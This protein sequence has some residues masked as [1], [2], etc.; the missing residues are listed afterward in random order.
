MYFLLVHGKQAWDSGWVGVSVIS[1]RK[2]WKDGQLTNRYWELEL[3]ILAQ[4]LQEKVW[5][6]CMS[7]AT[8]MVF[9]VCL[10]IRRDDKRQNCQVIDSCSTY[11][12]PSIA[13]QVALLIIW[14]VLGT[15]PTPLVR[16]CRTSRR[17]R[18]HSRSGVLSYSWW[19]QYPKAFL[20]CNSYKTW[21]CSF[22]HRTWESLYHWPANTLLIIT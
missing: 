10:Y 9:N 5:Y 13:V 17:R 21:R 19:R 2:Y 15:G 14:K 20:W 4:R 1:Y 12:W 8:C 11:S 16:A 7:Q 3:V 6:V 22:R 18:G